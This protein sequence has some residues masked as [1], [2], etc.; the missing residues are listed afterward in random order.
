MPLR[1]LGY[2]DELYSGYLTK[3]KLNKYGSTL[4][5]LPVPKLV[6]FYNGETEAEDEVMLRLTDSFPE[7]VRAESDIEVRVRMLNINYGRNKELLEACVP[8]SEYAWFVREIRRNRKN[9]SIEEAVDKAMNAMPDDYSIREFLVV[10]RAEVSSMLARDYS[11]DEIRELFMED[12]RKEGREEERKNTEAEKQ[13][14]DRAETELN[15]AKNKL[16]NTK[17]ELEDIKAELAKYK[18]KYGEVV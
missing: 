16:D 11:E 7:E 9:H 2:T 1:M 15:T 18:E 4:I 6:V 5:S 13:R 3:H 17:T 14:A 8:L 12:G 10:H